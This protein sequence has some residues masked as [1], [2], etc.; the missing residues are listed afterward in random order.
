MLLAGRITLLD[1]SGVPDVLPLCEERAVSVIAAGVFNSGI[2]ATRGAMRTS[3]TAKRR[4][5]CVA[6]RSRSSGS[7]SHVECR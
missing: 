6:V 2:L 1:N 4:T 7:A 3:N 5:P